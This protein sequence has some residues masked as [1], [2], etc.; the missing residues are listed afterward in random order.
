MTAPKCV[1]ATQDHI[2]WEI[3]VVVK[4]EEDAER[5]FTML[6]SM[7]E[8]FVDERIF[9]A[10]NA[11]ATKGIDN[12]LYFI[13]TTDRATNEVNRNRCIKAKIEKY[14]FYVSKSKIGPL[15]TLQ[16]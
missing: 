1:T 16:R 13:L 11:I 2:T 14:G 8:D 7:G 15:W 4:K 6:K 10:C 12:K 3:A 9:G 5:A